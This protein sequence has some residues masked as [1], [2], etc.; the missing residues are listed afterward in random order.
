MTIPL[1]VGRRRIALGALPSRSLESRF[2]LG[3]LLS[4]TD[5]SALLL[6]MFIAVSLREA[7]PLPWP[8]GGTVLI[9]PYA[10]AIPLG[11]WAC[12]YLFESYSDKWQGAGMTEYNR[13]LMASFT[14][15][16]VLAVGLYLS[17]STLSRG[18]YCWLVVVGILLLLAGRYV[19]RQ[20]TNRARACGR[21]VTNTILVGGAGHLAALLK[22]LAREEWLGYRVAGLL[23]P[24][25]DPDPSCGRIPI[26]GAPEDVMPVLRHAGV[27]AVIFTDGSFDQPSEFNELARQIEDLDAQTIFVPAV[28][29]VSPS[30]L[31]TRPVAGL[32][33]VHVQRP[34]AARACSWSKRLF[35][36]AG[37]VFALLLSAPVCLVAALLIKLTDGGPILYRQQRIGIGGKPFMLYKLRSM[38]VNADQ[39][40]DQLAAHSD[41]NGVLFKMARD[42]RITPVG[43]FIRRYSI[44]ELPQLLNVLKGDM[45]LVG[46]R[47]ALPSEVDRYDKYVRRR[48]AVR[49]GLSGLWQVSGRSNL[50]WDETVRLDLYYVDNWSMMQDLNILVR[51]I[52][53]V[54]R[55]DGAY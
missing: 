32:P 20:L 27:D 44:D 45:S 10:I 40:T 54:L 46:P 15:L 18:F 38:M 36:I 37:S 6:A 14:C 33:L 28:T 41:G 1:N 17:D 9:L 23:L 35:D 31:L 22:V 25:G 55:P 11:W 50:S 2:R 12:L 43:R 47:P 7:V 21:F 34:A 24:V 42:P 49:P 16:G 39:M 30:R 4:L 53:A 13:V 52:G 8:A 3:A 5:L 48:L 26:L 29:D 19:M 51:T